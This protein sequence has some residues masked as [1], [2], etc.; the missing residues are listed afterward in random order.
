MA[1]FDPPDDL[2]KVALL[3][4][5][6]NVGAKYFG[7]LIADLSAY[8]RVT[9]RKV[10]CNWTDTAMRKGWKEQ[11]VEH[12]AEGVHH[13]N[14]VPGKNSTDACMIVAAMDMLHTS[15]VDAICIASSDSD[16]TPL[17]IRLREAGLEVFGAG[18]HSTSRGFIAACDKFINVDE[19]VEAHA[20]MVSKD[21]K[22]KVAERPDTKKSALASKETEIAKVGNANGST[23]KVIETA[24][25]KVPTSPSSAALAI[26]QSKGVVGWLIDKLSGSTSKKQGTKAGIVAQKGDILGALDAMPPG[27]PLLGDVVAAMDSLG[28]SHPS[29]YASW[30]AY[31]TSDDCHFVTCFECPQLKKVKTVLE[32][33]DMS[34][35]QTLRVVRVI[36]PGASAE[37]IEAAARDL[38]YYVGRGEPVRLVDLAATWGTAH[39]YS[40]KKHGFKNFKDFIK[41]IEAFESVN[42]KV[43]KKQRIFITWKE[44]KMVSEVTKMSKT[45]PATQFHKNMT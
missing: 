22:S 45:P 13:A 17:A 41:S 26:E 8:G 23:G 29:K 28:I 36:Q 37:A 44:S 7:P 20:L 15:D 9:V 27:Y 24:A 31:L 11:L 4:D 18:D 3:V 40:V 10:F 43:K 16:F 25:A 21:S 6:D 14:L 2:P 39:G 35:E 32:R 38:Y 33:R 30:S 1:T 34:P 19:L 42:V 5:G 12:A